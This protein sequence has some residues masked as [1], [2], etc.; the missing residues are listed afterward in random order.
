MKFRCSQNSQSC[1]NRKDSQNCHEYYL[2]KCCRKGLMDILDKIPYILDGL[3]WWLEFGTLLGLH[4]DGKIIDWDYDLDV[5]INEDCLTQENINKIK[6]KSEEF[7]FVYKNIWSKGQ[8]KLIYSSTNFL[9][10]DFWVFRKNENNIMI[11]LSDITPTSHHEDF[12][13]EKDI[14]VF[15]NKN[16]FIPKN[17]NEFLTIRYGPSWSAPIKGIKSLKDGRTIFKDIEKNHNYKLEN[18]PIKNPNINKFPL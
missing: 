16:Y 14:L 18:I 15:N 13:K 4:R 9:F 12:T 3:D 17:I 2:K 5:G 10:C 1:P 7:G 6:S 8:H 11:P